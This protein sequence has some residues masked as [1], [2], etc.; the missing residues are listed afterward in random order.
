[1]VVSLADARG[2]LPMDK[3]LEM[4]LE[5]GVSF[6]HLATVRALHGKD[7]RRKSQTEL[8]DLSP[9]GSRKRGCCGP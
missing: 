1:V 2:S 7:R 9:K 3:L 4:Q 6:D 5:R 8:V